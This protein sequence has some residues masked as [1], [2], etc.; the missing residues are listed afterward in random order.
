MKAI[1]EKIATKYEEPRTNTE[2]LWKQNSRTHENKEQSCLRSLSEYSDSGMTHRSGVYPD[3]APEPSGFQKFHLS[4][5]GN[6]SG[7]PHHWS[8]WL[9][10]ECKK[11]SRFPNLPNLRFSLST[12]DSWSLRHPPPINHASQYSHLH[13]IHPLTESGLAQRNQ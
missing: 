11:E 12:C 2:F 8:F 7:D 10:G 1:E 6:E 9:Y 4:V 13:L 3:M 5:R